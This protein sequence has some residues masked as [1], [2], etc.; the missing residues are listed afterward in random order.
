MGD[1]PR[2]NDVDAT[3]RSSASGGCWSYWAAICP[4]APACIP[5]R[6]T[7]G[8]RPGV[9][10]CYAIKIRHAPGASGSGL[11]ALGLPIDCPS[12]S[13]LSRQVA[14]GRHRTFWWLA[15][16]KFC[17]HRWTGR[18]HHPHV[19][20]PTVIETVSVVNAGRA[21][22]MRTRLCRN[23]SRCPIRSADIC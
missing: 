8:A 12:A 18:C 4:D 1:A 19:V 23:A 22:G 11:S 10:R 2:S 5:L 15:F 14:V 13:A 9:S 7:G 21:A 6:A 20:G 3:W 17:P 16:A